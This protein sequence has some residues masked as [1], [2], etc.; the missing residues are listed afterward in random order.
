MQKYGYIALM[1]CL[2][3][4]GWIFPTVGQTQTVDVSIDPEQIIM[5]Q[6]AALEV[7][8]HIPIGSTLLWP[9]VADTLTGDIEIVR[10]GRPDTI[11]RDDG[12]ISLRQ[13][14][15]ITA[16]EEGFKPV[17]PMTFTGIVEQDT[18]V[19]ETRA[20]LLE[21]RGIELDPDADIRDIK[22]IFGIPLTFRD[23]LPWLGGLLFLLIAGWLL[24]KFF[25]RRKKKESTPTIWEKP[26]IPAHIA[27]LS[28][29]EQLK[30]RKLWQQGK[31]KLYHS[32]L[33]DI[34]RMYL[35]RRYGLHAP[36]MTTSEI[37][38]LAPSIIQ[39]DQAMQEFREIME[40]ADLVKFARYTPGASENETSLDLAFGFVGKTK[41]EVKDAE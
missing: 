12:M 13:R 28:S 23:L 24:Y 22:G 4:F 40:L 27:A 16:W 6:H 34:M 14:H 39:N 38:Q 8:I 11:S 31:V 5:G 3:G 25:R 2:V 36:E 29:L 32:D 33:T 9:G 26:D 35:Y 18:V 15:V 19:M 20:L 17:P 41:Q 10:F 30:S 1:L 7:V 21:V 37:L